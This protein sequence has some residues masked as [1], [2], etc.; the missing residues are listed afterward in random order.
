MKLPDYF[1]EK[2]YVNALGLPGPFQY[3][4]GEDIPLFGWYKDRPKKPQGF[5]NHVSHDFLSPIKDS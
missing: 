1:T 3:A 4:M 2:G 5:Q